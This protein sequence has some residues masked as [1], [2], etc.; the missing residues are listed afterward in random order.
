[1]KRMKRMMLLG[2]T[3]AMTVAASAQSLKINGVAQSNRHD[4]SEQMQT[5]YVGWNSELQKAI[6]V[7][8][9]G[10]YTMTWDGA[11]LTAPEKDP[12]V[13][14][15]DFYSEGKFTDNQKCLWANNFNLM[16]GNSGACYVNG[17]I[18]TV[19]SR[20]E[21]S[22]PDETLFNVRKWDAKTGALLSS[23]TRPKSALLESAGMS[24][25]PVDGKVYGLFYLTGQD[26][27]D[28]IKNDPEYFGDQDDD[29]TDGD[30][31]YCICTVDLATMKVT[32][33]TPGL[34]YQNFVAFAINVEGRAFALTSG[35]S[36]GYEGADGRMYNAN[37]QLTG[38]QLYE[39]DLQTG[40]MLTKGVEAIDPE[41]QEKYIEQVNI[42]DNATGYCS[43]YK[44]Q[45]ACFSKSDPNKLYWVGYYNSG[46]GYN[47]WGS[48]GPLPDRDSTT[49]QTWREN[50]KYDTALYEVD[51]NTGIGTR[52]SAIPERFSFS[53][54]WVDGD[55]P[56]DGADIDPF[57]PGVVGPGDGI[58]LAFHCAD[59]GF[60]WQP[61]EMG[62]TY[63]YFIEPAQGW[64]VHS[65]SFNGSELNVDENGYVTTLPVNAERNHLIVVFEKV[66]DVE[67]IAAVQADDIH[68]VAAQ[69]GL[70]IQGAQAGQPAVVYTLDGRKVSSHVLSG[71]DD[72]L[73]LPSG[74]LYIVKVGQ[75][76][77]KVRM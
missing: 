48:F 56:S 55:D 13:N 20:D 6:F 45:S 68:I 39:F 19:M 3:A 40:L 33:V 10:I 9:Q 23:E 42:Y 65:I 49:G 24:Y 69:Q 17:K 72:V 5:Q 41:T 47:A 63:S 71:S 37:N 28:E 75:K 7:Y 18:V 50:H 1:M 15:E 74:S 44:R 38:A 43:Q 32:P 11:S 76:V 58:F 62:K 60:I 21:Q 16:Y 22:T 54:L 31:G 59:G 66:N 36:A 73:E 61:V 53:A 52:L 70:R 77:V 29:M 57:Q 27:P 35:G 46:K 30:A 4:D 8:E 12:A 67:G 51:I 34:Y 26:L 14:I 25:N 2:L 64:A